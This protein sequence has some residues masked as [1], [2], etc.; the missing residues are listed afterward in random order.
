MSY[1]THPLG[2]INIHRTWNKPT[3]KRSNLKRIINGDAWMDYNWPLLTI[4][5][6]NII[7][8]YLS[9]YV[10]SSENTGK[11]TM[12][13]S[14]FQ[15]RPSHSLVMS[16]SWNYHPTFGAKQ[17]PGWRK[18]FYLFLSKYFHLS[19]M[20]HQFKRKIKCI[21]S[22]FLHSSSPNSLKPVSLMMSISYALFLTIISS[23]FIFVRPDATDALLCQ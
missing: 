12:P 2:E 20:S 17:L 23:I 6:F 14:Q 5:I 7:Y 9:K 11:G 16:S 19:F 3:G 15:S 18:F 1:T 22:I 21:F 4:S 10:V 8:L 13:W